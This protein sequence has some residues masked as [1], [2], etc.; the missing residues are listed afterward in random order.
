MAE[1]LAAIPTFTLRL[2]WSTDVGGPMVTQVTFDFMRPDWREYGDME[3]GEYENT[4][5]AATP[6]LPCA[7]CLIVN[8]LSFTN[9]APTFKERVTEILVRAIA[10][11]KVNQYVLASAPPAYPVGPPRPL[12]IGWPLSG[13]A[14]GR[15]V[16]GVGSLPALR[17]LTVA[18]R[19]CA[20][21]EFAA[22]DEV[23]NIYRGSAPPPS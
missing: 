5:P 10:R 21:A 13:Q 14:V 12:G 3:I 17:G 16:S 6:P 9:E 2:P 23:L 15:L 22:Q 18:L 20:A 19:L 11:W 7:F 1:L 8:Q 4:G